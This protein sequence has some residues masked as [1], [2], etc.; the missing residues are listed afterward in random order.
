ME[1]GQVAA[2]REEE[3]GENG[4]VDVK[5]RDGLCT[6]QTGHRIMASRHYDRGSVPRFFCC[7]ISGASKSMSRWGGCECSFFFFSS[8]MYY[9]GR[10]WQP[11]RGVILWV[12]EELPLVS[13]VLGMSSRRRAVESAGLGAGDMAG[14]GLLQR[15][16]YQRD[17][18]H[19][20]FLCVLFPPTGKTDRPQRQEI[21]AKCQPP[22]TPPARPIQ[23]RHT[24]P[25]TGYTR[26]PASPGSSS[27]PFFTSSHP[28]CAGCCASCAR[29]A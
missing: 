28:T 7:L 5:R 10:F 19:S 13:R 26:M 2:A 9:I 18:S 29:C 14:K 20:E 4:E 3:D 21:K 27:I 25:Q 11:E 6:G 17:I 22:V 8:L 16:K 12:V 24:Q 23:S 15:L 1:R